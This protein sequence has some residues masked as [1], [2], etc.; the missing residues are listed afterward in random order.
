MQLCTSHD[1][2]AVRPI[3]QRCIGFTAIE[4]L[5][6]VAIIAILAS[7]A[8]P[9]FVSTI[10]HYRLSSENSDLLLDLMAAR[11]EALRLGATVSVCPSSNG[12]QCSGSNWGSGRI[13]FVDG[14]TAGTVDAN[15]TI[16]KVSPAIDPKDTM[17][18]SFATDYVQYNSMGAANLA[19][20]ITTCRS[21]FTGFQLALQL[22]GRVG[23]ITL[24]GV[25]P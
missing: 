17:T 21:G 24:T 22:I 11:S 6:T 4:M 9:S 20:T 14:G 23:S 19:G 18:A 7:M 16:L 1:T 15:D 2:V 10:A 12:T 13:V 25:C 5:V 8:V 3:H